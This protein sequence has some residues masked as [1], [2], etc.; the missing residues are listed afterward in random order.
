MQLWPLGDNYNASHNTFTKQRVSVTG[1]VYFAHHGFCSLGIPSHHISA[2]L[3][4]LGII[5]I[6]ATVML[7]LMWF[8]MAS[9]RSE[10]A[11]THLLSCTALAVE[12]RIHEQ[13]TGWCMMRQHHKHCL[14]FLP[15]CWYTGWSMAEDWQSRSR[16]WEGC[17]SSGTA[18]SILL[19]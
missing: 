4:I 6:A 18:V 8:Q 11:C 5:S 17:H 3:R 16:H 19:H 13:D 10:A 1:T 14:P 7:T 9:F 2:R 15:G 12:A